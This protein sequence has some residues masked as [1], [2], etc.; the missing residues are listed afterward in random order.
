MFFFLFFFSSSFVF[1]VCFPGWTRPTPV[2]QPQGGPGWGDWIFRMNI[3]ELTEPHDV[4]RVDTAW[5]GTGRTYQG[6]PWH[7][8][9]FRSKDK[10]SFFFFRDLGCHHFFKQRMQIKPG[11]VESSQRGSSWRIMSFRG[12]KPQ[13]L[14]FVDTS[15]GFFWCCCFLFACLFFNSTLGIIS[16]RQFHKILH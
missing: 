10:F 12:W 11:D 7:K 14:F 3:L 16:E 5:Q 15:Q 6:K 9:V 2:L 1:L 4:Q 8:S 13:H